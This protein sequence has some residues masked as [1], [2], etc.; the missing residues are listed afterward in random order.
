VSQAG[1][2]GRIVE[3]H[4]ALDTPDELDYREALDWFGLRFAD[5]PGG[6]PEVLPDASDARV[7]HFER[8]VGLNAP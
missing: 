7:R 5:E 3:Q 4:S 2:R 6:R 8:L 1:C